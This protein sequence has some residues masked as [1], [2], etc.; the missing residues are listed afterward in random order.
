[1]P[2]GDDGVG[3]IG[4]DD[5]QRKDASEFTDGRTYCLF[6]RL[7]VLQIFLD[8]MRNDFGICFR[9]ET[10]IRLTQSLFEL[11][12]VLDDAV[13]NNDDTPGTVAVWM[14]VLLSWTTMC[15]PARMSD[16]VSSVD[17]GLSGSLLR[18]SEVFPPP[19]GFPGC[20]RR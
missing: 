17:A 11:K 12:I 18:G 4:I 5:R 19:F 14:R 8:Q 7:I 9:D 10:M 20:D 3:L 1:M 16:S 6:E 2:Y 13:M 15:G